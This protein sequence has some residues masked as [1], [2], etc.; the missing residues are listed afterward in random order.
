MARARQKS[1]SILAT[2]ALIG[3]LLGVWVPASSLQSFTCTYNDVVGLVTVEIAAGGSATVERAGDFVEVNGTR[4]VDG[5]TDA[6][7]ANT[8][9]INIVGGAGGQRAVVSLASGR[10]EPGRTDEPG[11]SDEIEIYVSL[12][13]GTDSLRVMGGNQRD[14]IVAGTTGQPRIN[15][16][17]GEGDTVDY[18]LSVMDNVE[19]LAIDGNGRADSISA[20]GSFGTGSVLRRAITIAGGDGNDN[21]T[22]GAG[23]D[24]L[25]DKTGTGDADVLIGKGGG[26]TL[27]TRDGDGRD[28]A[29]G[30]PGTDTCAVDGGDT[31]IAC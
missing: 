16:N 17:A 7:V 12:G 24:V 23:A 21:L 9:V 11:T 29:I 1:G 2:A 15:L 3:A 22:G 10:F 14:S 27:S 6:T 19:L 30:G 5:A 31:A 13:G 18:D 20:T 4:C 25:T 26:D 28:R 8:E